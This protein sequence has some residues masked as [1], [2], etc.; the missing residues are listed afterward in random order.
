L[1]TGAASTPTYKV[2]HALH[3]GSPGTPATINGYNLV[4]PLSCTTGYL[5]I[6]GFVSSWSLDLHDAASVQ[7]FALRNHDFV[8]NMV[9]A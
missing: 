3:L 4:Q 5:G 2:N 1:R 6:Y 8:F 7:R 9:L